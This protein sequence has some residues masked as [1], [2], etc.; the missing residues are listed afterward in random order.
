MKI[1]VINGSHRTHGN[2][3]R[4][5]RFFCDQ[6]EKFGHEANIID[7]VDTPF[8]FCDGCL[9]CEDVGYCVLDDNFSKALVPQIIDSDL[10]LFA[11]P[12]YYNMPTAMMKSFIERA[13]GL[14]KYFKKNKK[15]ASCFL[16]GQ[17]DDE[18][19]AAAWRC[20]KDIIELYRLEIWGEPLLRIAR[21]PDELIMDDSIKNHVQNWFQF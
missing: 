13:N 14:Y 8:Q 18:S 3:W 1:I 5:A 7:L 21:N 4:F 20:M 10:I 17:A 2:T 19:L 16:V 11:S 9:A 12:V 15:K 6:A